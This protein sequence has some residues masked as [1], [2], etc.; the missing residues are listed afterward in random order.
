MRTRH[1]TL[2]QHSLHPWSW[3]ASVAAGAAVALSAL[4]LWAVGC[5]DAG[6][7]ESREGGDVVTRPLP[8]GAVAP[9]EHAPA[10]PVV[11]GPVSFSDARTAYRENRF[12]EAVTLFTVY[13][14]EHPDDAAGQY[15]LGLSQWKSGHHTLA[16]QPLETAIALDST[17]RHAVY[18]LTRVLL[19]LNRPSDALDRIKGAVAGDSTDG[20]AWR[21][22]ARTRAGLGQFSDAIDGYKKAIVLDSTDVWSMNNLALIYFEQGRTAD[23]LPPLAK[24]VVL[25]PGSAQLQNSLG[26]VLER[27]GYATAAA[28]A[29]RAAVAADSGYTRA[30][31]N[32]ARVD[33]KP[34]AD[35]LAPLDLSALAESFLATIR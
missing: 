9:V 21:L 24:A 30:V 29:Y 11:T 15:L 34:D 32:L 25:K 6:H 27:A 4:T 10:A 33:G 35:G 12:D 8:A 16:I 26:M 7:A 31:T 1:F 20:E 28:S 14:Q 18:N 3:R 5:G 17:R 2:D 22:L 19:E 23:A 13:T